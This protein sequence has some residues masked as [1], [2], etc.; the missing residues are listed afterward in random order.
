MTIDHDAHMHLDPSN[1]P[2]WMEPSPHTRRRTDPK[3][4]LWLRLARWVWGWL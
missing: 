3:P 4:P 1:R 2:R